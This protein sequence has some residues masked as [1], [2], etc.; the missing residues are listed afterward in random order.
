[1][2]FGCLL[3]RLCGCYVTAKSDQ[4]GDVSYQSG[5]GFAGLRFRALGFGG[6]K[7]LGAEGSG[8]SGFCGS[9]AEGFG[10]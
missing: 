10:V 7:L 1:M 6:C 9:W 8:G 2:T 5:E 3:L 4:A